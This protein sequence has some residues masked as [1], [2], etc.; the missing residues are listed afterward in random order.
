MFLTA[1]TAYNGLASVCLLCCLFV[2][3]WK[4]LDA[5]LT[6]QGSAFLSPQKCPKNQPKRYP[7]TD[8]KR[9]MQESPELIRT[10][11]HFGPNLTACKRKSR[12]Q[13][14]CFAHLFGLLLPAVAC[15]MLALCLSCDSPA[16]AFG[17]YSASVLLGAGAILV[18]KRILGAVLGSLWCS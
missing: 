2:A 3:P 12:E 1:Q 13:L 6:P 16:T 8:P 10:Q 15:F 9:E 7:K 11:A 18:S 5:F 14:L 4:P 17:Y